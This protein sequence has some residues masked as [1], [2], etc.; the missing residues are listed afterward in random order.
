M[1]KQFI[2]QERD[3]LKRRNFYEYITKKYILKVRME[4][5]EMVDNKFPF[6]VDF[7]DK[8][9]WVC[10]SITC[11]AMASQSKKIISIEEFKKKEGRI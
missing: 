10:E 6:V 1:S 7:D 2:V 4:K 9:F 5:E 11:C 8:T 3:Y